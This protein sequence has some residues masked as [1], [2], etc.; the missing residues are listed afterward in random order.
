MFHV[1]TTFISC[2]SNGKAKSSYCAIKLPRSEQC[3]GTTKHCVTLCKLVC[4][5]FWYVLSFGLATI[6]LG[7]PV[8]YIEGSQAMIYK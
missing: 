2:H 6:S 4:S 3:R 7:W 8:V 5:F 1:F